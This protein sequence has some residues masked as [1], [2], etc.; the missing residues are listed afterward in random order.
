[1]CSYWLERMANV[2]RIVDDLLVGTSV[3]DRIVILDNGN[4]NWWTT[5]E[6]DPRRVGRFTDPRVSVLTPSW[7]TECRGK[8]MTGLLDVAH[9]YLFMDDDTSVG[10]RTVEVLEHWAEESESDEFV[11]G[12]WGVHLKNRSF[13][14]GDLVFPSEVPAPVQVDAFHGRGMFCSFGALV[15]TLD[16]EQRVRLAGSDVAW[17]TEGDD[18]IIGLANPKSSWIVPL[19]GDANFVDLDPGAEAMQNRVGYFDMRDEFCEAVLTARE[20]SAP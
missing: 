5:L 1:M 11:T 16:L 6:D 4:R 14:H 13:M 2:H 7:N 18:L 8:F 12:Y 9:H 15:R 10:R 3:P 17:P 20:R 19:R